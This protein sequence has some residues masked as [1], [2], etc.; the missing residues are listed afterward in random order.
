MGPCKAWPLQRGGVGERLTC[1]GRATLLPDPHMRDSAIDGTSPRMTRRDDRSSRCHGQIPVRMPRPAF[2][3]VHEAV[4]AAADPRPWPVPPALVAVMAQ[5]GDA[6][7][8]EGSIE[9]EQAH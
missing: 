3:P 5:D 2:D 1:G 6:M 7:A 4:G 9:H 8:S